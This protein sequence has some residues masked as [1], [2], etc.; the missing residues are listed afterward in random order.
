[1]AAAD[2]AWDGMRCEFLYDADGNV[3]GHA[4]VSPGIS[5]EG[6]AALAELVA[7]AVRLQ[8]ARDAADPEAA[9][10]RARRQER[11]RER[12]RRW[13][14]QSSKVSRQRRRS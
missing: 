4:R 12:M 9:A 10:E 5:D 11:M 6:R 3:I 7:A 1:M 8:A 14:G 13:R 2:G